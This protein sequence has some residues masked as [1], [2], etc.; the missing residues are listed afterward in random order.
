MIDFDMVR[1]IFGGKLTQSQVDGINTLLEAWE[2]HGDGND[3]HLAYLLAT[4]KHETA[5]TMQP[6]Y[7]RGRTAYFDKYNVG[8]KIGKALG[9]TQ[10][11]DGFKYRGRGYVQLTG[12]AN[13]DKAGKKLG[14]N[15][16]DNP[17]E[18]LKPDVAAAVLITG[19][20]EG[21][22]TGKKLSNYQDFISMRRVING[23]D[24]AA[25]IATY[26]DSFY[27]AVKG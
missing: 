26:A 11:G 8:T 22:F 13:Y 5:S 19:C 10:A 21:W 27:A 20:L 2:K 23:T 4:A 9:N 15:L 1:P 18:A 7:E 14:L 16:I 12:R 25:F 6:I 24:K 17:D 3:R